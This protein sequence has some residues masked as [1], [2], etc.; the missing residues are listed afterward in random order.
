MGFVAP[1]NPK[2]CPTAD[3]IRKLVALVDLAQSQKRQ[4]AIIEV[5][6]NVKA[7][8]REDDVRHTVNLKHR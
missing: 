3:P 6:R 8:N 1:L 4:Q 2:C 7:R 5:M